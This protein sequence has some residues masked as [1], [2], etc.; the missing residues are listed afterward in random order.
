MIEDPEDFL[1]MTL[2]GTA[3]EVIKISRDLRDIEDSVMTSISDGNILPEQVME[4]Q[5]FD[6]ADQTLQQ[7]ASLLYNLS[8]D[9]TRET[10]ESMS[11]AIDNLN[12]GGLAANLRPSDGSDDERAEAPPAV[13]M[14]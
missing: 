3:R 9:A 14:F 12:L 1:S 5:R 11:M 6:L 13:D 4:L 10:I 7:I 8:N 2:R